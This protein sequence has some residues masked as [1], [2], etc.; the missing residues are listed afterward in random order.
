MT[1]C[2]R[3]PAF[4]LAAAASPCDEAKAALAREELS[5][6]ALDSLYSTIAS[7]RREIHA[8]PEPGFEEKKTNAL[9]RNMLT[10]LAGIP[11]SAF[12]NSAGTGLIVDLVG[13]GPGKAP[14]GT[15]VRTIV[16]SICRVDDAEVRAFISRSPM[17]PKQLNASLRHDTNALLASIRAADDAGATA[18]ST[19]A[20]AAAVA[21]GPL[22]SAHLGQMEGALQ[23]LLDEVYFVNDLLE[24]LAGQLE[25]RNSHR[26]EIII[27]ILILIEIMLEVGKDV[28]LHGFPNVPRLARLPFAGLSLLW[29]RFAQSA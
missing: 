20:A 14:E 16:L 12:S 1:S 4:P 8:N 7:L 18:G 10:T 29:G 13:E 26:L 17:L 27:I 6:E 5:P 9:L 22:S 24:S 15:A 11:E 28:A 25:I 21:G 2:H 23:L 19:A 3:V